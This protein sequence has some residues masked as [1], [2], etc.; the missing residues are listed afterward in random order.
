MKY[1]W[2]E[3][4]EQFLENVV[5]GHKISSQ[6]IA[7]IE[8]GS[9]RFGSTFYYIQIATQGFKFMIEVNQSKARIMKLS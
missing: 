4:H 6:Y 9:G 3:I 1:L 2:R 7:R 8:T 5:S